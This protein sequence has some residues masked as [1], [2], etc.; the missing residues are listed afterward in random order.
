M[1]LQAWMMDALYSMHECGRKGNNN[2]WGGEGVGGACP[3]MFIT[4]MYVRSSA[5]QNTMVRST[6]LRSNRVK[7]WQSN[8]QPSSQ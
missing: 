5:P 6:P 3:C 8:C 7:N 1:S 2:R 4:F